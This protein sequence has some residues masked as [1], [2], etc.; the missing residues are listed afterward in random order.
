MLP[1]TAGR[2]IMRGLVRGGAALAVLALA[3]GGAAQAEKA[4]FISCAGFEEEIPH[5]DIDTCPGH[6]VKPEEGVC[7]VSLAGST[8]QI[9]LFRHVGGETSSTTSSR[10]SG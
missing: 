6:L 1:G 3:A 7:R 10:A 4:C 5:L 2:R 8:G 9:Y